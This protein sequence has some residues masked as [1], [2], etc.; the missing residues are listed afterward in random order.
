MLSS[1]FETFS[2]RSRVTVCDLMGRC[3]RCNERMT[4]KLLLRHKCGGQKHCKICKRQVDEDHK[5]YV[6][7]K[8]KH[9][10]SVKDR[11]RPLQMYIYFD[12]ECTQE[13]GIHVPNLC[14][15]HR[16]CQHCD[17]LPINEPCKRCEAF[18]PRRHVFHRTQNP[19]GFHGLATC[20]YP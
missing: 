8:P 13:N 10:D 14:V 5:C 7:I 11:K 12:F 1:T 15:A 9:K 16:V 4:K 20:H 19:K 3:D 6:Q 18:G 2:D 17:H